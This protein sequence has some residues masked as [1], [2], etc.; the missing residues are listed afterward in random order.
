MNFQELLNKIRKLSPAFD[1]AT[2]EFAGY[3]F[4][5]V[6]ERLWATTADLQG[7]VE[8]RPALAWLRDAV[9][10]LEKCAARS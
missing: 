8:G 7:H 9:E 10:E 1:G 6:N 2:F 3:S 4:L 5:I